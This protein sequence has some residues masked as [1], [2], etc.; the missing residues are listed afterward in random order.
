MLVFHPD[1]E[2][3]DLSNWHVALGGAKLNRQLAERAMELGVIAQSCYGMTET[4]PAM[5][6]GMLKP[7]HYDLSPQ[8]KITYYIKS[9]IPWLFS[10]FR[11][12]DENWNDVP[13]DGRTVGDIVVRT[14]WCTHEY[15]KE[16][17]KTKEL[18]KNNWLNTGDVGVIDEEGYLMV[19]DRNK[20]V[21]KS[22][23]EW[24]STL[25]LEDVIS[26]FPP[27]L[28]CAVIGIPDPKWDERPCACIAFKEGQSATPEEIRDWIMKFTE[29][30][31]IEKWWVPDIP[32]GY[33]FVDEI[34]H[35]YIGKIEK[36]TLR[37]MYAEKAEHE[38]A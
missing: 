32:N 15:F 28:E 13:H 36:N 4:C 5:T 8:E 9:G 17:E 26:Q 7:E 29:D 20:D 35:N 24:I 31:T 6:L 30:G 14:P 34:P 2:K 18:W 21:I 16:P 19:T 12:V 25:T 27:V 3:Y 38:R 10:Q 37:K 22:G 11:V 23:G 33:F 1:A